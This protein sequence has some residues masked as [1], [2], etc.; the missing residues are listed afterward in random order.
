[1]YHSPGFINRD[2]LITIILGFVVGLIFA[3]GV[4]TAQ[5]SLKNP[6]QIISPQPTTI[7]ASESAQLNSDQPPTDTSTNQA[8]EKI[9]T[10]SYPYQYLL[11]D[12]KKLTVKGRANQQASI[13]LIA[14][15]GQQTAV[16]DQ[17]NDFVLDVNL[18]TGINNLAVFAVWPDGQTQRTDLQVILSATPLE[19]N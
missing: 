13:L 4:W 11:T 5:Q 10:I 6:Q 9:F 2:L 17:D 7:P 8:G 18:I 3:Y 12:N 15:S 1:M 16:P 19:D 14:E